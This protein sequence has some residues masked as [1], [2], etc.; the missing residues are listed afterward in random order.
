[1]AV[2]KKKTSPSR[3]DKRRGG[4]TH[5][6]GP[7]TLTVSPINKELVRPHTVTL[8]TLDAYIAARNERKANKSQSSTNK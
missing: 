8:D 2:P 1:M 6:L 3:R 4:A 5:K 7:V